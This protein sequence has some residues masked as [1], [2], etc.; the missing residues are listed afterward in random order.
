[1]KASLPVVALMCLTFAAR[2]AAAEEYAGCP[3]AGVLSAKLITDI[4]WDC[5]FP[6]RIAGVS[7][8]GGSAPPGAADG[9]LCTCQDDAGL[10]A[11]GFTMGMWEPARLVELVRHPGCSMALNGTRLP[12]TNGRQQGT[13]GRGEEGIH[14]RGAYHYHYYAFPLLRMLDLFVDRRCSSD[15][16]LDFDV[17]YLSELD[18][19]WNNDE[20]AFFVNP[21]AAAVANP[22]AIAACAADAARTETGWPTDN[23]FWCAG[24]WGHLYPLSW[25]VYGSHGMVRQTSLLATRAIAAQHRRGLEWRTKGEDTLC[26]ARIDPMMTKTQYRMSM[27]FPVPETDSAH[28]IGHSTDFWGANRSIPA[29]GEDA[30]YVLWRW[31]D[32]CITP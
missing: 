30:L 22:L 31:R 21:E 11:P 5:I 14:D 1:M 24:A 12:I 3:N 17:M 4:C 10:P 15:G 32:C 23:L 9:A 7:I 25:K 16:F 2:P 20:L 8:G 27:F 26:K 6:L 18:P 29:V 19:T 13:A 28:V